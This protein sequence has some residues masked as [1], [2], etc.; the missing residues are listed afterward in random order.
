[1]QRY[2]DDYDG[3]VS[4]AP[5]YD[6][7]VQTS[8]LFRLQFFQRD[9]ASKLTPAEVALVNKAALAACDLNDGVK[10]GIIANPPTCKWD[11]VQLACT[12]SSAPGTCLTERQV[13][14]V[15]RSYAGISTRDGRVA[16]WPLPRGGELQWTLRSIGGTPDNPIGTNFP[17]G[18]VYLLDVLF[19]DPGRAW[20]SITPDQALGY[21]QQSEAA[22]LV[23][24]T[25]PDVAPFFKHGGKWIIWH[26]EYDPGPSPLGTLEYYHAMLKA[27]AAKLGVNPAALDDDVRVF[28]APGVYHC[29]GGP[30]PDR[31]DM[32]AALDDWVAAGRAP[33]S[34]IATKLGSPIS[35]PLCVYPAAA[36]YAGTGDIDRA[37][38]YACK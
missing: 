30:G 15:R 14:A 22:P 32:V 8:A 35:R 27:T 36:H 9:P 16:A 1:V 7:R 26:G 18:V 37:E 38:N 24:A 23:Q 20:D 2:P 4:G 33:A 31:F 10:D 5:V 13:A 25:D 6:L 11:P 17:L 29:G 21:V 34:I 3:V 28:L 19:A 12:P